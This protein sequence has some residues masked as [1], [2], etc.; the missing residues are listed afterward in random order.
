[1]RP[2]KGMKVKR[3]S[4]HTVLITVGLD[5]YAIFT[6]SNVDGNNI[7]LKGCTNIF[8]AKR[9]EPYISNSDILAQKLKRR[10]K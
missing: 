7:M 10:N 8:D 2:K 4:H 9:F 6:I 1:M 5:P 3:I